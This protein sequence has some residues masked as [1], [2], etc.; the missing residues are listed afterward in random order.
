M[1]EVFPEQLGNVSLEDFHR[2][3][4]VVRPSLIRTDADEVTYNLH[5][6]LRFDLEIR[7]LEGKLKVVD[8]PD[9]WN[10]RIQDDLG[11][12]VPDDRDGCMQDVH[13][14]GGLIGGMFQGYTLGNVMSG[15]FWEAALA[16]HPEIPEELAEGRFDT[17]H[18]WLTENILQHGSRYE[19][20]E[21]VERATGKPLGVD[22]FA[23]YL[24]DKYGTLYSLRS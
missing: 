16:A 15:Q 10:A 12:D 22:A 23:R 13:W 7:M 5:V 21:I 9:A 8:L 6:M 2:A 17:L 3:I 14:Y 1:Q 18:A 11:V 24:R 4:N 20:M 19:P